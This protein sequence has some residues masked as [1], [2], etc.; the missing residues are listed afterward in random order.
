MKNTHFVLAMTAALATWCAAS[1]AHA[2][3]IPG[4]GATPGATQLGAT[5]AVAFQVAESGPGHA[6]VVPYFTV[7]NGQ[8]SVLHLVNTDLAN[9]KAVKLRY[10]DAGNGDYLLSLQVLLAP[11]DVWT[12]VVTQGADGL[13]QILTADNSCT[14]PRLTPGGPAQPFGTHRLNPAATAQAR[15]QQTREGTVEAIVMAD[16]PSAAVYGPGANSRSALSAT[17]Q[18]VGGLARC[19]TDVLDAALLTNTSSEGVAASRG[20]ASPSGGLTGSWYIID[21][22]GSTTFSGAATAIRAVNGAGQP[23]RGNYVLF[24]QSGDDVTAPEFYTADP[25]LA[26]G[27]FASRVKQANGLTS[28]PTTAAVVRAKYYD[29][30]DL[31]TPY[32]LPSNVANARTTAGDLTRAM[33]VASVTNQYATDA[34]ISAKTDWVL[35]L[36][37]RRYSVGIDY[38]VPAPDAR[39][40][41]VVPAANGGNNQ[42]FHSGNTS[43]DST[44]V[45]ATI[46][47]A[48]VFQYSR[49]NRV[50]SPG[51]QGTQIFADRE[52]TLASGGAMS[53]P[54]NPALCGAVSVVAFT[55][56]GASALGA[57]VVRETATNGPF[58]NGWS[59][60]P[61]TS[62]TTQ[63]GLPL[64]GSAFIKLSNPSAQPGVSGNYGITWPHNFTR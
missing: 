31:S 32:Y 4:T 48:P 20:F 58:T 2:G 11:G 16:I 30:P 37:T 42:Y 18:P 39:V 45:Y 17:I 26:S 34:S 21:V 55:D 14:Y 38:S 44:P 40:F 12:G 1:P 50:C 6:L 5:D 52:A 10:R 54:F 62:P 29:L 53:L 28:S 57:S 51:P 33:A 64:L 60:F 19:D 7:Q 8:M 47:G 35:S 22:P 61:L 15:Q 3:V 56:T 27:G 9:G 63:L 59:R 49:P 25:L 43:V 24:P 41:S 36:P 46:E 13:A 23:A